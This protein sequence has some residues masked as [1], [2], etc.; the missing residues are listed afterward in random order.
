MRG[1]FLI[2]YLISQKDQSVDSFKYAAI[3]ILQRFMM[4]GENV[5]LIIK[6]RAVEPLGGGE[7]TLSIP[8]IKQLKPVQVNKACILY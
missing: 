6:K 4:T 1:L 3:P 2:L 8:N 7:I 5:E